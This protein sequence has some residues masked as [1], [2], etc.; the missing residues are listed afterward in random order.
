MYIQLQSALV[1]II[2]SLA[3]LTLSTCNT[4]YMYS[5]L[6]LFIKEVKDT[7]FSQHDFEKDWI[8]RIKE[9]GSAKYWYVA[10]LF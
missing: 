6:L 3:S 4:L 8:R 2:K 1:N 5:F 7:N 9:H 10:L